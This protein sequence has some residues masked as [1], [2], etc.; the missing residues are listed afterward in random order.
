[1]IEISIISVVCLFF[2][3]FFVRRFIN[4]RRV[5]KRIERIRNMFQ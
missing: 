4:K 3:V 5:E 2:V 1:M